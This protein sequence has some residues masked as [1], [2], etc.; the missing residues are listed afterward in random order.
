LEQFRGVQLNQLAFIDEFGATTN[1]TRTRARAP[2]GQRA[3]GKIPHGH[4]KVLTTIA[5]LTVCGMLCSA[6]FDGATDRELFEI[7]VRDLLVPLLVP[8]Q[9][10][11]MD[12]LSSHKSPAVRQQIEAA[13]CRLL[14]LPPYSPDFNPIEM[15]ISKVK[16][17]LRSQ[18]HRT[19]DPLLNGIGPALASVTVADAKHY[20]EHCGYAATSACKPL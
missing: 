13:G 7:F 2:R 16:T 8:G 3:V 20:I 15:A 4:W 10:V 17:F 9:V 14:Y 6:S 12:N 1:M 11:V 5:V 18:E 19:L